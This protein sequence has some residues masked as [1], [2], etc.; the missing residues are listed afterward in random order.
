VTASNTISQKPSF[1]REGQDKTVTLSDFETR[2]VIG[3]GSTGK[4]L[5]VQRKNK[6]ELV[7][8]MK[9][10]SK[11]KMLDYGLIDQT[12][13][14]KD[15]LCNSRSPFLMPMYYV[16]QSPEKI[17]FVMPFLRGGDMFTLMRKS[18]RFTEERARFY[19]C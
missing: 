17:M 13:L 2:S 14:E 4:V 18:G 12:K 5:L 8:A 9:S 3:K 6:P 10:I 7:F 1:I 15:I 16:F 11:E 19:A